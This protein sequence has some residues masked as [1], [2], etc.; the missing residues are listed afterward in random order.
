MNQTTSMASLQQ[1]LNN[2]P[3]ALIALR[4]GREIVATLI[5]LAPSNAQ[6]KKDLASFDA[7]IARL[8]ERAQEAGKN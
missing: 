7:E 1:K 2:T 6:W 8:E 5:T 4:K 3:E